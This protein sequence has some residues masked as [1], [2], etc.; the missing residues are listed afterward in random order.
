MWITLLTQRWKN[1]EFANYVQ[2]L[3][4]EFKEKFD[5]YRALLLEYNER[6]N[7]TTILEEKDIFY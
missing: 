5:A 3:T 7:L 1:M 6:Y 2:L 4:G